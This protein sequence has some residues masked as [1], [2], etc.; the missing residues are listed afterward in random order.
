MFIYCAALPGLYCHQ[1]LLLHMP[2]I[3]QSQFLL[4]DKNPKL[5]PSDNRVDGIFIT[6]KTQRN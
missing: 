5:Y 1:T 6:N 4:P 3:Y 2:F